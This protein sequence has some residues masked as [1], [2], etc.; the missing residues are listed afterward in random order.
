[1]LL[2]LLARQYRHG[3]TVGDAIAAP[4][5]VLSGAELGWATWADADGIRVAV[6]DTAPTAWFE[7]LEERGHTAVPARAG[8]GAFGHAHC[9]RV[10]DDHLEGA[11][12]PRSLNGAAAGL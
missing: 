11:A 2:Q 9:I 3:Q 12:D 7:G 8:T 10:G 6:E 4:R 1:V 5:W